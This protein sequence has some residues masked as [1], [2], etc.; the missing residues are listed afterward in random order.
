[1][2]LQYCHPEEV[3]KI[4]LKQLNFKVKYYLKHHFMNTNAKNLDIMEKVRQYIDDN[5]D[6]LFQ[7]G[8][9]KKKMNQSMK[10]GKSVNEIRIMNYK[11]K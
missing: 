2:N 8:M 4:R 6:S 1:M 10:K 9:D 5:I 7:F 3:N 11:E